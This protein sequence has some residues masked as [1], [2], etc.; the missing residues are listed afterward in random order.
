MM[1]LV[2]RL[3]WLLVCMVFVILSGIVIR[4]VRKNVYNLIEIDI[5][6]FD[7]IRFYML[8]C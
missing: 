4:Y 8:W 2:I 3:N 1:M 6:N 7:L 5:G